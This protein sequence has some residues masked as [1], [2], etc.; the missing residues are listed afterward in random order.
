MD[1]V[2]KELEESAKELDFGKCADSSSSQLCWYARWC[3]QEHNIQKPF[4][5]P[6]PYLEVWSDY[7]L[8]SMLSSNPRA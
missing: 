7:Q 4:P 5:I 3:S 2:L 1:E 6:V 8:K